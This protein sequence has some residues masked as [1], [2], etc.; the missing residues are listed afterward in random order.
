[1]G[2]G[3]RE[4]VNNLNHIEM[5][6]ATF[7]EGFSHLQLTLSRQTRDLPHHAHFLK[8]F[9]SFGCSIHLPQIKT[10]EQSQNSQARL[11]STSAYW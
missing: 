1:M 5:L 8:I 6:I 10:A 7:K 4:D 9:L 2:W 11:H 3:I